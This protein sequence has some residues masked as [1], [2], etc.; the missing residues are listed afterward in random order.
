MPDTPPVVTANKAR[1]LVL[2]LVV[3][4]EEVVVF[5]EVVVLVVLGLVVV[6]V[7]VLEVVE[8]AALPQPVNTKTSARAKITKIPDVFI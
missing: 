6:E 2:I 3:K 4:M 1:A 8:V 5:V 7:V